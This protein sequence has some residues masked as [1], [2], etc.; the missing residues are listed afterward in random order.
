MDEKM[1]FVARRK[2]GLRGYRVQYVVGLPFPWVEQGNLQHAHVYQY[3]RQDGALV[4]SP[5]K[6]HGPEEA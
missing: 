5:R 6:L 3:V 4:I 2:I 1:F